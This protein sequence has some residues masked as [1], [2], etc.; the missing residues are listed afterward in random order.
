M[1]GSEPQRAPRRVNEWGYIREEVTDDV[2][3][4]FGIRTSTDGDSPEDAEA[5]RAPAG[6]V[7]EFGILC[8]A[9]SKVDA[10]STTTTLYLP[11]DATYHDV[12]R[13]LAISESTAAWTRR[14]ISRPAGAAPGFLT[15]L[16]EMMRSSAAVARE[17]D[18]TPV[19]PRQT[20]V[21]KGAVYDLIVRRI[22]R[23]PQ[24]RTRS[25]VFENVLRARGL[26]SKPGDRRDH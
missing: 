2:T 16:D 9:V 23:V 22:E 21:Y 8:S 12:D 5:R 11:R 4:V 14:D 7:A 18:T 25:A 17:I 1:I 20:F 3:T 19:V 13:V 26:D 15:A 10:R 24:L 6:G